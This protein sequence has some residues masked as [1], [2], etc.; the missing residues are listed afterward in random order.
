MPRAGVAVVTL[1]LPYALVAL[2]CS[3]SSAP[4]VASGPVDAAAGPQP[5]GAPCD[6][7]LAAPCLPT[8][9]PCLGVQCLPAAPGST[10]FACSEHEVPDAGATCSGGT[11]PCA[12]LTDCAAGLTCGFPIGGGC[13]AEGRCINLP[14]VCE[15]DAA[16]C[17]GVGAVCGCN[18]LAVPIV[19]VGYA[20][21][22]TPA[23][24]ASSAD[25]ECAGDDAGL[26]DSDGAAAND[27]AND[28][29]AATD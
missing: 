18:G 15:E 27:A 23:S 12:T 22:P 11:T 29:G 9:D 14:L 24:A 28:A 7:S 8:G 3:S 17:G 21:A 25:A 10:A 6:P 1:A 16:A 19:I 13:A 2:A 26:S 5:I 4:A 20:G